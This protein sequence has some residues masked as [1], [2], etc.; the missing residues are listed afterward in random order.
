MVEKVH[1][2]QITVRRM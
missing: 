2:W 1:P